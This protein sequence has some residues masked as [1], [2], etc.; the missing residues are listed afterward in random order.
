MP[1]A[2]SKTLAGMTNG[3]E[4]RAFL[5]MAETS[6]HRA[7]ESSK[8]NYRERHGVTLGLQRIEKHTNMETWS[9]VGSSSKDFELEE[10]GLTAGTGVLTRKQVQ[11]SEMGMLLFW[12]A[13]RSITISGL[14]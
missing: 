10:H 4:L 5:K 7:T 2:S 12:I 1:R 11:R 14:E 8:N 9:E 3:V 6:N 13:R